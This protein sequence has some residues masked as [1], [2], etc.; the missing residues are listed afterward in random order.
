MNFNSTHVVEEMKNVLRFWVKKGA[1]GFRVDATDHI[2]EAFDFRDQPLSGKTNDTKDYGYHL[3]IATRDQPANFEIVYQW[4]EVLDSLKSVNGGYS[5]ILMA[6]TYAN[7]SHMQS[8]FQSP[9]GKRQGANVPLNN[10]LIDRTTEYTNASELKAL[11][12]YGL[13]YVPEGKWVSWIVSNHDKHRI[14]TKMGEGK[15]DCY[16]TLVMTL[17]GIAITYQVI[18]ILSL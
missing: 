18:L 4:R 8:F 11:V 2:F 10:L 13:K 15:I 6:E 7:N 9:D 17:P 16:N 14:G 5:K 3:H 1:A 12:D